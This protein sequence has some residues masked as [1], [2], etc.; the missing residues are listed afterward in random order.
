M[1]KNICEQIALHCILNITAK[2][3]TNQTGKDDPNLHGLLNYISL[4]KST[5]K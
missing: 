3:Q 5:K 2:F 4:K 1:F